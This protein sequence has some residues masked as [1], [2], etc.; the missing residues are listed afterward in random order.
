MIGLIWLLMQK[1]EKVYGLESKTFTL[2]DRKFISSA[3]RPL[4]LT[5]EV[6]TAVV[7]KSSVF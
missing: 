5:A 1:I 2:R 4:Y 7:I 6:F 3:T